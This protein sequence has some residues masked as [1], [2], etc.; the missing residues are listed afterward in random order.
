MVM[1]LNEITDRREA[2]RRGWRALGWLLALAALGFLAFD[3]TEWQQHGGAFKTTSAAWPWLLF[4]GSAP[5]PFEGLEH[6]IWP[7]L[8][9]FIAGTA[10]VVLDWPAFLVFGLPGLAILYTG[11]GR[12][13]RTRPW[14]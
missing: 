6:Y 7:A 3:L 8:A 1:M 10:R 13:A 2:M 4:Q 9:R 5:A 12:S 14:R 11:Y